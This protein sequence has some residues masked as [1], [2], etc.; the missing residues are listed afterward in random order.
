[1]RKSQYTEDQIEYALRQE[2][3]GTPVAEEI[4]GMGITKQTFYRWKKKY[5]GLCTGY[6]FRK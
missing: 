3:H 4:R 6:S 1:M 2:E 5:A